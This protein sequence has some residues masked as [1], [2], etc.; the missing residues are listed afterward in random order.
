MG[1]RLLVTESCGCGAKMGEDT[2]SWWVRRGSFGA[3]KGCQQLVSAGV[4]CRL[5]GC[6][7]SERRVKVEVRLSAACEQAWVDV[8]MMLR[9]W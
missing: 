7:A 8:E 3:W 9:A 4:W 5:I 2:V 6:R 1:G